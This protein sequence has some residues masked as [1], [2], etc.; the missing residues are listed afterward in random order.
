MS[1]HEF[2]Q[3]DDQSDAEEPPIEFHASS[4]LPFRLDDYFEITP[5]GLNV[6]GNPTFED[7]EE[8]WEKLLTTEKAIQFV[9][10][11]AMR[12]FRARFG[13]RADQIISDRTGWTFETLR[14]YE[15]VA[16]EVP[17]HVRRLDKLSFSH[18][19]VVASCSP[20]EQQKWLNKAADDE[21]PWP[22]KR[23]TEAIKTNTDANPTVWVVVA[24]CTSEVERDTL[25]AELESRN[26]KCKTS[27]RHAAA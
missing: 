19:Q 16:K 11:D 26:I 10:G 1:V 17:A 23:L 18:H 15:W 24:Y 14:N 8:L 3:H 27:E 6:I 2:A 7:C 12:F 25:A 13:E 21:K 22:V 5:Q 4:L 9:I 20:I